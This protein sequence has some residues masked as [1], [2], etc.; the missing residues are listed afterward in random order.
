METMFPD[1]GRWTPS[2]A[3]L[4]AQVASAGSARVGATIDFAHS[5]LNNGYRPYDYLTE[6]AV[7]APHARHL[8][9]HDNFGRPAQFRPW[10]HG[11][12]IMLGFGDL[13]L[14][15][16]AGSVPWDALSALPYGG[17]AVANLEIDKRWAPEWAGAIAW[18]R[19]WVGRM[20]TPAPS[21]GAA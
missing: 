21:T 9:V 10:S 18:A 12:G 4:A 6:M 16:G 2:P 15:P 11:D 17:P 5:W 3:E 19:R 8:H 14:P 13:H 1:P 20:R 7:L